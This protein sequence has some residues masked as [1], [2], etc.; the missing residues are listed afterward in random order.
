MTRMF[1]SGAAGAEASARPACES[2][3]SRHIK[4][5]L[6]ARSSSLHYFC[7]WGLCYS[8]DKKTKTHI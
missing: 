1:E 6:N 5:V 2:G 7:L 4:I 3:S 8:L